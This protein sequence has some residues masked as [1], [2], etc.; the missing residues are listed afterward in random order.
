MRVLVTGGSG[1]IGRWVV[2]RLLDGG[3]DVRSLDLAPGEEPGA[4]YIVGDTRRREVVEAALR[5]CDS[6][7]HLAEIPNAAAPFPSDEIYWR[8]AQSMA[9]VFKAAA[10]LGI[11][12][13]VYSSSCQ[14]YGCWGQNSVAPLR[15]PIDEN[16]PVNPRNVYAVSKAANELFVQNLARESTLGVSIFRFPWVVTRPDEEQRLTGGRGIADGPLGDGLGTFVHA[17]DLARAMEAAVENGHGGCEVYNLASSDVISVIPIG[18]RL[19]HHHPDFPRLPA[20]WPEHQSPILLTKAEKMLG[21]R[22]QWTFRGHLL[23][24]ASRT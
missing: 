9:T 20:D 2:R 18:I 19:A 13:A 14:V 23:A 6:L 3:H 1:R 12:H 11:R 21:W 4:N 16:T 17:S 15:L 10:D 7:I 5:G 24:M 22:P 8:N